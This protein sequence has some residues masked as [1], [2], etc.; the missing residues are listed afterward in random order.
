MSQRLLLKP[1]RKTTKE[2]EQI[3]KA[4]KSKCEIQGKCCNLV[5]DGGST[6]NLVSMKVMEK[7]K[8]KDVE[9]S[10][11]IRQKINLYSAS[12]FLLLVN[13]EQVI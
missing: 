5:I 13:S 2:L 6:K 11:S 7:L 10:K 4:F 9:F 3:K 1:K 8:L 12:L